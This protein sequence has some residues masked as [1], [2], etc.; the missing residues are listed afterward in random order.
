MSTSLGSFPC[1]VCT[2]DKH[3]AADLVCAA[4][5]T[6]VSAADQAELIELRR[7]ANGSDTHRIKCNAVVRELARALTA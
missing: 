1:P 7:K 4:C 2:A 6:N 3:K 5:W